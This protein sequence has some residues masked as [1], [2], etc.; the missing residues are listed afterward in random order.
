MTPA[1]MVDVIIPNFNG[2]KYL[3]VCLD[4]LSRQT[5]N[6]FK[7]MMID[8]CSED[9]SVS[10]VK[11]KYPHVSVLEFH[12]NKGFSMAVNEG[13]RRT[14]GELVFLL[15]SDTELDERCIESLVSAFQEENEVAIAAPRV[16]MFD[17]RDIIDSAGILYRIDG[18]SRG[19]GTGCRDSEEYGISKL[20]FG[21]SAGAAAY[22]R[23][24]LNEI[25]LLDEDFK[26]YYEDTDLS[27]RALL[28]G[29]RCLYVPSAVVYHHG[30]Q[31]RHS[32]FTRYY[33]TRN[34]IYTLVKN[35]PA[36]LLI[37]YFPYIVFYQVYQS[38]FA[39]SKGKIAIDV[40]ARFDAL[41][42]LAKMMRKRKEIQKRRTMS[43]SELARVITHE[44]ER[45]P[46]SE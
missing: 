2:M 38:F 39:A 42:G 3:P 12:Q 8:D 1:N 33:T 41:S 11:E 5:F 21:A 28:R 36:R 29:Y 46:K 26:F 20:I 31:Q 10:Y 9:G 34:L 37:K 30:G 32:D 22:R 23:T 6:N 35:M 43:C 4:S 13:I 40:K 7:I 19:A 27:F 15:N 17:R 45:V 16:L 44:F 24:L 25:G 18:L 14:S